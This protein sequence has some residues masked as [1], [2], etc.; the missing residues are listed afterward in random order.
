M[1]ERGFGGLRYGGQLGT[2]A[3]YRAYAKYANRDEFTR[4]DGSGAND[5]WW[6]SQQGFRVDWEPADINRFSLQ[7]DYYY[8]KWDG[9]IRRHSL[10]PPGLF[11]D[12]IRAKSEGAIRD[13]EVDR[14]VYAK[15]T[16]R[17]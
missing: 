9:L 13:V 15:V 4:T 16:W 11:T 5:S 3:Y 1:E 10:S 7:G 14:A 17:F 8:G 2:N 12:R 6:I